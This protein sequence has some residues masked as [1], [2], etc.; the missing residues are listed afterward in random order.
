[1]LPGHL[2]EVSHPSEWPE[3]RAELLK[4]EFAKQSLGKLISTHV[5]VP[6]SQIS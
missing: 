3:S 2:D 1:M 5:S 6:Q 4:S